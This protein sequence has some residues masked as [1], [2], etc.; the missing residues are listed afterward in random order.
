MIKRERYISQ[1]R[2]FYDSDLIKIITGIRRSGK[3]VILSQIKEEISRY[4][5]NVI[6]LNF[7]D[8]T[9]RR[10]IQTGDDLIDYVDQIRDN[11]LWYVFLDEIQN[12]PDW[13]EACK[14]L[15]LHGCSLFITGSNSKLLS[16]EFTKELSGRYV[17]FQIHPFVY[18]EL[19]EYAFQLN[20][21]VSITDYLIWGGF[22]G[23]LPLPSEDAMRT[24]L[25]D[26]DETIVINDII[27]RYKI[28]KTDEFQRFVNYILVSNARE[29]SF[30][31]ITGYMASHGTKT[32]KTTIKKWLEYLE[33]AYVI[34]RIK[35]YSTKAKRELDYSFKLY[36]ED[37]AMNS[38]RV[39]NNRFDLSHN[40][41]NIILNEL[42]YKGYNVSVFQN[43]G[44]E[45]DFL[46]QKNS[47]IYYIQ[48]ALSVQEEK[49]YEREFSAFNKL[50]QSNRKILITNDELDYSTS[51]VDHVKLIDFLKADEL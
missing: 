37:V 25:L 4:S 15:R 21:T 33:E 11:Q 49:A 40:L 32:S 16:R 30:N 38:I 13:N 50:D 14:T 2:A 42:R 34:Q 22:P 20:K 41:E 39:A 9:V 47:K 5:S 29:F 23:R 17:S 19:T 27:N 28:R 7:E 48:V 43:S 10:K 3:S 51:T 35:P 8:R 24:Y 31:S 26:L 12:L 1:I 44:R 6:S 45:I 36:N 18:K 46:A